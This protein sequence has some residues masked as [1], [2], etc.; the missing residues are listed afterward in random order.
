MQKID[1]QTLTTQ[2]SNQEQFIDKQ[3]WRVPKEQRYQAVAKIVKAWSQYDS[4]RETQYQISSRLYANLNIM[5]LNGLSYSKITS[6]QNSLKDRITFNVVQS[7]IDTITAKIAKNRPKP[8]FLT[9]GGDYKV[10]R[11]AKKMNKFVD[12]LF[13]ENHA[14]DLGVEIFRDAAVFGDGFIHVFE[15]NGRVKFERVPPSELYVDWVESF[16]GQPR[17]LHRVKNIDRE[18]LI[19]MFPGK[20]EKILQANSASADLTG[21]YQNVAD[22]VTVVE[23]WHLPSGVGATDGIHTINMEG[24]NLFEE[25]YDKGFFPFAHFS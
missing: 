14:Y 8:L 24:C 13:Y 23:S 5:G 11:K 10:Q 16:Y 25:K 18:V 7:A 6:V 20:K 19:A 2:G 17:Q 9:S 22:Q 1:Y 15:H 3:W 4:K 12:G 21:I